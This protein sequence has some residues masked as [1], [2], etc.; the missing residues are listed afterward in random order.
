MIDKLKEITEIRINNVTYKVI[1]HAGGDLKWLAICFGINAANSSYPCLWCDWKMKDK[2]EANDIKMNLPLNRSHNEAKK[3]LKKRDIDEKKGYINEALF[4][5]IPFDRM[6]VD[7]LH[8]TLR[9]T[10][11]LFEELL[12]RLQELD[13][14]KNSSNWEE[15]Q[16]SNDLRIFIEK[17]CRVTCPFY[18]KEKDLVSKI[19]IRKL[20]QNERMNILDELSNADKNRTLASIFTDPKHRQ[21]GIILRISRIF[22]EFSQIM[23]I[24]KKSSQD[25][26][27]AALND[28]LRNWLRY[29]TQVQDKITPYIHVFIYHL[30]FFIQK[31]NCLNL[32]SMQGLEKTNHI[33]KI[34]FHRQTN[35]HKSQFTKILME[36]INRKEFIHLKGMLDN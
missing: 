25:I 32:F 4:P 7:I 33:A 16:A 21:D 34:F 13:G 1:F 5:F 12:L 17:E 14:S 8:L 23:K 28:K 36:K 31:F 6:V 15:R 11:K 26:D 18:V 27:M 30:P 24:V 29:F 2:L 19:K 3:C 22:Y 35:H 20:N 9:I 10:D